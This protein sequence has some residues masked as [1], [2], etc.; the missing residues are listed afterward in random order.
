MRFPGHRLALPVGVFPKR[1]LKSPKTPNIK[2]FR[3]NQVQRRRRNSLR[4]LRNVSEDDRRRIVEVLGARW[5]LRKIL[6]CGILSARMYAEPLA[7]A[8]AQ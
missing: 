5:S 6:R 3:I 2:K 4:R 8:V 1:P 7:A